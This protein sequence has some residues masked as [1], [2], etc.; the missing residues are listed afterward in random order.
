MIRNCYI[1]KPNLLAA[2]QARI[3]HL[4]QI[5]S[6]RKSWAKTE[7]GKWRHSAELGKRRRSAGRPGEE[8][9]TSGDEHKEEEEKT[10]GEASASTLVHATDAAGNQSC[11]SDESGDGGEGSDSDGRTMQAA[12]PYY[13]P[14][15][16][17]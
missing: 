7:I 2:A 1:A 4:I 3:V 12:G 10:S 6:H 5:G 17:P 9:E 13:G 16:E 15:A 11:N 8:E 14:T